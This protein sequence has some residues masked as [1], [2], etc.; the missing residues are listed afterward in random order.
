MAASNDKSKNA[1][2]KMADGY[3]FS[4]EGRFTRKFQN[5]LIS[6]I[7]FREN[8]NIL[9]VACGTG[10]LLTSLHKQKPIN[11]FGIGIADQMIKNAA[12]NNPTME[13]HVSGCETIPFQNETMDIITVCVAYHH[14]P[15][16]A[17]FAK[18]AKRVLKT[19]GKI[20]IAE[21]Y[22]PAI[23]R[24]I[25]NPFVPLSNSGDVKFYSP[26]EIIRN[27][28]KLGFEKPEVKITG[29]IQIVSMQKL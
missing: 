7:I 27:F 28:K 11:G 12:V 3:D 6:N 22:L 29:H 9:D 25:C 10:S 14:F 18:E 5:R 8:Q 20:Y 4:P 26:K 15:D 13:F 16:V 21:I 17:A 1:Y 23:L 2:N 19:R 24:I